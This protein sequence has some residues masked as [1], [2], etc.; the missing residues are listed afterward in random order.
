MDT[1]KSL[2]GKYHVQSGGA[3]LGNVKLVNSVT[4]IPIPDDEPII[5]FRGKDEA[6]VDT[7]VEYQNFCGRLGS[8]ESHIEAIDDLIDRVIWWQEQNPDKVKVPD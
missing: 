1:D 3:N 4:N 2:D 5:I 7:L 6:L 8:P